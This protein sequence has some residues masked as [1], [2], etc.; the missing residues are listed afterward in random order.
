MSSKSAAYEF[1]TAG[2][3]NGVSWCR[4]VSLRPVANSAGKTTLIRHVLGLTRLNRFVR[5]LRSADPVG[6]FA[7]GYLSEEGD[8]PG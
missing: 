2:I 6:V 1:G 8:L 3:D 7:Q 4:A 5:Q